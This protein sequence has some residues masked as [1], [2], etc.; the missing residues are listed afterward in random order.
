MSGLDEHSTFEHPLTEVADRRK[1]EAYD[2]LVC[3]RHIV[4]D[5]VGYQS[6][7]LDGSG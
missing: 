6:Q 4:L 2:E 5:R 7:N 3:V 1:R